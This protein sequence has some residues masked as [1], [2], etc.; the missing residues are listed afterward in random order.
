MQ[1]SHLIDIRNIVLSDNNIK[2]RFGDPLKQSKPGKHLNEIVFDKYN[3][4]NLCVVKVYT[5]YLDLTSKLRG[6]T[7]RLFISFLAPYECVR[8]DTIS[9]WIKTVM[10]SAGIDTNTFKPHSV[11]SASVSAVSSKL[12]LGT[13]SK[14][15]A[16]ATHVH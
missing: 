6:N 2:I 12:P 9:R 7:T 16:G 5:K 11:R 15:L 8:T 14:Q 4:K 10:N 13:L 1:S 3:D